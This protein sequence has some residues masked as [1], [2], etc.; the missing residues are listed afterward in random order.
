MDE[1]MRKKHEIILTERKKMLITAIKDVFSFDEQLIE[2]ETIDGYLD[3]RGSNLHIVKM[4]LESGEMLVE[5]KINNIE[6]YN[7]THDKKKSF[8]I[9]KK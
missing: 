9:F 5:G 4:N 2:L 7:G 6:Y 8:R 1:K 3:I